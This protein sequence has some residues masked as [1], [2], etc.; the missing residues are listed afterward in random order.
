MEHFSRGGRKGEDGMKPPQWDMHQMNDIPRK[1]TPPAASAADHAIMKRVMRFLCWSNRSDLAKDLNDAINAP[2]AQ[3]A[4]AEVD[5]IAL[6][7]AVIVQRDRANENERKLR[8]AEEQL[9]QYR[10]PIRNGDDLPNPTNE[11][12]S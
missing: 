3:L 4:R 5:V 6:R 12:P 2:I 7:E 11:H 8:E 9:A 10:R 1:P